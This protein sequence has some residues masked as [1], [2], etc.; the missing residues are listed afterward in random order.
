MINGQGPFRFMVDTGANHS[1]VA[2]RITQALHLNPGSSAS[3]I[4]NGVTGSALVP[5]VHV[6]RLQ[7]GDLVLEQRQLPVLEYVLANADGILGVEGFADKRIVVDFEHDR[8]TIARSRN[9]RAPFGYVEIPVKLRFGRLLIIDVAIGRVHAKGVI[10][11]GSEA[12]LGNR[13]LA[14]EIGVRVNPRKP[15]TEVFGATQELQH[16]SSVTIPQISLGGT[17]IANASVTFGDL[18]VFR[19]WELERQPAVLIGM[20]VLGKLGTLVIDYRRRELQI[21]LPRTG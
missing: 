19:L 17:H 2:L 14:R 12:T 16:G 13:A 10:D 6:D 9:Q 3:V 1:A 21:K 18:Y 15:P 20:D 4:L 7:A 11:T 5:T 8:I